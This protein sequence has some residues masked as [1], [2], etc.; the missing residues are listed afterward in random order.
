M[1]LSLEFLGADKIR[2]T[3]LPKSLFVAADVRRLKSSGLE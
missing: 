2:L 1:I 3:A